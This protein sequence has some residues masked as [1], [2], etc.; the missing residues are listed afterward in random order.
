MKLFS[1]LNVDKGIRKA[2]GEMGFIEMTEVQSKVIPAVLEGKDVIA[3]SITG[4]GKTAAFGVPISEKVEHGKGLQAVII[5]PTR[6]LVNQVSAE[7]QKFSRHKYLNIATVF[8]GVSIVPQIQKLRSS[9]IVVGTPGRMLDHMQRGTLR[10]D[11]VKILVLDEAD[12]M[13]DMGFIDDIRKIISQIPRARQTMLFSATMPEEIVDIARR[14]MNHPVKITGERYVSTN[15]LK[16]YY[17]D[18]KQEEKISLLE[19]LINTEKPSLAIVFCAM[20]GITNFVARELGNAGVD[21]KAIH[22]GIEQSSRMNILEGFHRGRPH[23]LIATDVAARGLDIKNVSHIFNYDIPKTA[24]D[25][26][27]RVGRTARFGKTGKS[28]SLLSRED[29]EL[30]RKIIRS[31]E[32]EKLQ[33]PADFKPRSI[34]YTREHRS[35]GNRRFG[36]RRP[37]FGR[38]RF[39]SNSSGG[40]RFSG[41][42]SYRR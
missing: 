1:E 22:G 20:R 21:V 25:Y 31:I 42:R 41:R 35:F 27:H 32:I 9:E 16:H 37:G 15:L 38:S 10:M 11:N 17:Y 29:H 39:S 2:L 5:G 36:S 40:R 8:G 6:E 13:L 18:I 28:I 26:T 33:L 3:Q 23:I 24:E 7:M 19:Y 14:F 12:R 4:S 34:F 30:F